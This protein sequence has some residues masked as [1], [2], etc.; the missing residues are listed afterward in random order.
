[1]MCKFCREEI[2]ESLKAPSHARRVLSWH[3]QC[4]QFVAMNG[5]QKVMYGD[6]DMTSTVLA[7]EFK[8]DEDAE[9]GVHDTVQGSV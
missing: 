9:N 3:W 7:V 4:F 8:R 2:D 1:M 6:E 5:M